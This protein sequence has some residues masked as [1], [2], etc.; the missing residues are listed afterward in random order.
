MN[1]LSLFEVAPT[2]PNIKP[3]ACVIWLHGLGANNRDFVE[4]LPYL[5][6]P[7]ALAIHFVFPQAP[8]IPVTVNQGYVMPAW[9]DILSINIE[10][11]VDKTQL[12]A[13]AAQIERL[14]EEQIKKG[15]A[16]ER[17]VLVGFSQ[18]GAVAIQTALT[19]RY[20]L[21]G[22]AVLSSYLAIPEAFNTPTPSQRLP[23][24]IQHGNQDDV[25]PLSLGERAATEFRHHGFNVQW[26]SFAMAHQVNL[27]SLEALGQW[28]V[29]VLP[30]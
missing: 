1:T 18:G 20:K 8:S 11:T 28:L 26:Q 23:V 21:G 25:V 15:M 13:S 3:N 6:I 5:K 4:T 30:V 9:Y 27:A 16:P 29:R 10:R 7:A 19:C 17:I 2:H 22:L 14:I 12:I 24:L